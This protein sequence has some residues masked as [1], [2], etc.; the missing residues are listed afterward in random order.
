M[1]DLPVQF[2]IAFLKSIVP[3]SALGGKSGVQ[4]S[5][6]VFLKQPWGPKHFKGPRQANRFQNAVQNRTVKSDV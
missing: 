4:T 3:K 1:S 2:Y 6:K 5:N